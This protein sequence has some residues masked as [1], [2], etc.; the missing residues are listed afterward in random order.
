MPGASS[1]PENAV[2]VSRSSGFGFESLRLDLLASTASPRPWP[3]NSDGA[4]R[5]AL[6]RAIE[7]FDGGLGEGAR[8]GPD[9]AGWPT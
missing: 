7:P 1:P 5:G 6:D 9:A 8:S 4:R 3:S 2:A